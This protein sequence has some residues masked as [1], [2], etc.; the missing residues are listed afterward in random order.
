MITDVDRY[1]G[2]HPAMLIGA[3]WGT[4]DLKMRSQPETL[5]TSHELISVQAM[6]DPKHNE[7]P[8]AH[9]I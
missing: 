7:N 2:H 4:L 9:H 1:M 8:K 6:P 3:W 5:S